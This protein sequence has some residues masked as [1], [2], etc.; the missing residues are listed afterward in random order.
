MEPEKANE[1][2]VVPGELRLL[3][4]DP[5]PEGVRPAVL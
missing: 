4:G 3:L 5:G 1:K 2:G